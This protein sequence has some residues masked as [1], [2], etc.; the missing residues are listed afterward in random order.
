MK[1]LR[2]SLVNYLIDAIL[3]AILGVVMLIWPGVT[4]KV[5]CILIGVILIGLSLIKVIMHFVRP[6]EEGGMPFTLLAGLI[7]AALG[8]ALVIYHESFIDIFHII[9][10]V[11][12]IYG[13]IVAFVQAIKL[14]KVKLI[15]SILLFIAAAA[16]LVLGVIILINPMAWAGF[17]IRLQG[18]ALIA[19]SVAAVIILLRAMKA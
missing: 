13:S 17:I 14:L 8:L 3:L 11:L 2:S 10:A 1:G 7:E 16:A 12:L 9:T 4:M 15:W 19:M 18:L 5:V 6:A